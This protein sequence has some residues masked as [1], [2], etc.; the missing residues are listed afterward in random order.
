MA[1]RDHRSNCSRSSCTSE[2]SAFGR[3]VLGIPQSRTYLPNSRRR[4]LVEYPG[5]FDGEI[6][7]SHDYRTPGP[8]TA[9]RVLVVGSGQSAAEIATE[10]SRVAACCYMAVR[11]GAHVIPRWIAGAPYDASDVEPLNR[12]PW[13]LLNMVYGRRVAAELGPLPPEWPSA[14]SRVLEGVPIVSSDLVPAVRRGEVAIKPAVDRLQGDRVVFVD[15]SAERIDA[16]ICATGYRISV[17]FLPSG[18]LA[19]SGRD[20]PLYRRIVPPA[21]AGLFLGGFVDAPGG[22]LPVVE[23]QADWIAAAVTGRLSLPPP[24]RMWAAIERGER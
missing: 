8:F 15:G 20:V 11:T 23:T 3:P 1:R 4:T 7:H 12:M 22:L 14:D 10:V 9:R 6:S 13:R 18:R 21:L 16:I 5:R 19:A 2:S 24:R 17:P